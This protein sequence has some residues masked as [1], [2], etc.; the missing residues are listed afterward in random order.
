MVVFQNRL[1]YTVHDT[2]EL[3][4]LNLDS[5]ETRSFELGRIFPESMTQMQLAI[6]RGMRRLYIIQ[7]G[8]FIR[9][10]D[11]DSESWTAPHEIPGIEYSG[12]AA[13]NDAGVLYL[14]DDERNGIHVM[15]ASQGYVG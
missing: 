1:Y 14:L 15:N 4:I 9:V 3:R 5:G 12:G 10:F 6:N 11:I 8:I 7:P 13:L 2:Q